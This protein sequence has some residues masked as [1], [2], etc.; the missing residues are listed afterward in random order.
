MWRKKGDFNK[1]SVK[2]SHGTLLAGSSCFLL[3]FLKNVRTSY[4][5]FLIIMANNEA[6]RDE[7]LGKHIPMEWVGTLNQNSDNS[8]NWT[9][10]VTVQRENT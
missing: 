10:E 3:F 6:T 4:P 5:L 8:E 2:S 1:H 9:E 7:F